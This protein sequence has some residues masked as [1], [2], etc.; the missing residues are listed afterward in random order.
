MSNQD[1]NSLNEFK[2]INNKVKKDCL[3]RLELVQINVVGQT[4]QLMSHITV[5]FYKVLQ[6]TSGSHPY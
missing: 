2:R 5:Y 6:N 1:L 4:D 3:P